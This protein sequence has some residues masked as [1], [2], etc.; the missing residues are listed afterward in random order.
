MLLLHKSEIDNN[1]SYS[2]NNVGITSNDIGR[3]GS[4]SIKKK[5]CI[6]ENMYIKSDLDL[7]HST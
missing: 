3:T 1:V 7:E 6:I 2:N 5:A 4:G